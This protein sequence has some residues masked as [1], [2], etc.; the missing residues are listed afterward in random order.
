MAAPNIFSKP[1]LRFVHQ[2][3]LKMMLQPAEITVALNKKFGTNFEKGQVQRAISSRGWSR[4]RKK[5][6]EDL[7]GVETVSDRRIVSSLARKHEEVMAE[8]A[9]GALGGARRALQFAQT[10]ENVR[11]LAAAGSAAKSFFSTFALASGIENKANRPTGHSYTFN[12]ASTPVKRVG[13]ATKIVSPVSVD[14]VAG[15]GE[16]APVDVELNDK[17]SG[18][19]GL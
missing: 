17:S 7:E 16:A 10:A 8:M 3:Y 19:A 14:G 1:H 13:V 4:R 9:E 15:V 6:E 2:S 5:I 12:F 18:P 11:S